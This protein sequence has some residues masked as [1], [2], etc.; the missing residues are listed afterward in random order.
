MDNRDSN[1]IAV[2]LDQNS[3]IHLRHTSDILN[4]NLVDAMSEVQI[5]KIHNGN[6]D[7]RELNNRRL[8]VKECKEEQ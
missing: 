3:K 4:T 2:K 7:E 6:G 8:D 1:R 5:M